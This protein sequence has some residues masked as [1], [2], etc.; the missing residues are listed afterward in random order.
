[1]LNDLEALEYLWKHNLFESDVQRIGVE[2]ELCFVDKH[3][4]PALVE[5]EVLEKLEEPNYTTEYAMFNMEINLDPQL[6]SGSCLADM[7]RQLL[8][9]LKKGEK[10][11]NEVGAHLIITGILPLM[12]IPS[13]V[14]IHPAEVGIITP[15]KPLLS[16]L[17]Y[18][19]RRM[20]ASRAL[21]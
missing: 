11:A 2:Q 16:R 17:T 18:F 8:Y 10:A 20:E 12:R 19:A 3:W 14:S 6:F 5:M 15:M 13:L 21:L 4:R 9:F 1:L 7:E